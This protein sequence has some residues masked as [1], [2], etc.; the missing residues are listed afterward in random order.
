MTETEWTREYT[1]NI[2]RFLFPVKSKPILQQDTWVESCWHNSGLL[3]YFALK[4]L[5][6]KYHVNISSDLNTNIV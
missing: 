4:N 3:K 6:K 5:W 1:E 2:S